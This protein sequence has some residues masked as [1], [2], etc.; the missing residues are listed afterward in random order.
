MGHIEL[1]KWADAVVIAPAS[2][3]C[4]S[5]LAQGRADDLLTAVCLATPAPLA[6]APAMNQQMWKDPATQ[7]N[8]AILSSRGIHIFGPAEGDQACG[9]R[10]P[11]RLL[12][13]KDLVD[14]VAGLFE[15]GALAGLKVLVTSGSTREPIDPVRFISNRSS[16]LMGTAVAQAAIEA[17]A[18]CTMISGPS[19]YPAPDKVTRINVE[20]AQQ[21]H[22]Q[23]MN[24][25]SDFDIFIATAAVSDYRPSEQH[26]QKIKKD[27]QELTIK[28][29]R[30]PDILADVAKECSGKFCVGFAA[31]TIDVEKNAIQ[32][33]N[34][35]SL[36]VVV[37]NDVKR[38]DIGF[39]SPENEV[40]VYWQ[41]GE[42]KLEKSSKHQIARQLIEIIA[43]LFK[44]QNV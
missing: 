16:G 42:K 40:T 4:I 13:P 12:E 24:K 32:K 34:N 6:I 26:D 3:N 37:A 9:D 1:A 41:G 19:D 23:V 35:K 30:N 10:G 5:R 39:D 33:L 21:M 7:E 29:T 11:G 43:G 44:N 38:E 14:S 27:Q 31:E 2:A 22:E 20:T 15:T 28:L 17:G 36:N 25:I 18:H 8:I